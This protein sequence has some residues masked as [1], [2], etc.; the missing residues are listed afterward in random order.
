M[1]DLSLEN[2][3]HQPDK[4]GQPRLGSFYEHSQPAW[5]GV[6]PASAGKTL[7][8]NNSRLPQPHPYQHMLSARNVKLGNEFHFSNLRLS[9]R[10]ISEG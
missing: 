4:V 2:E 6:T 7:G 8:Q 9:Q 3:L 5:A 10:L 1:E